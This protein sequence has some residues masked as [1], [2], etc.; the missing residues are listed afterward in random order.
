M[1]DSHFQAWG[2]YRKHKYS[3]KELFAPLEAILVPIFFVL[4]GIQVKLESFLDPQ[5]LL[6]SAGLTLVAVLG[7]LVAGLGV[8][9]ADRQA[10]GGGHWHDATG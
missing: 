8:M 4:M 5:V 6:L 7:K 1:L 9:G 2:D 10:F 3:I